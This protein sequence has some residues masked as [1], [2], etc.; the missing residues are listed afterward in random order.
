MVRIALATTFSL[1]RRDTHRCSGA[2]RRECRRA[3]HVVDQTDPAIDPPPDTDDRRTA[4]R[5]PDHGP[6]IADPVYATLLNHENPRRELDGADSPVR[7][8]ARRPE[9]AGEPRRHGLDAGR[10]RLDRHRP[11]TTDSA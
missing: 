9:S 10:R 8:P 5:T 4:T 1:R 6:R 7:C 11:R 3:A 2:E